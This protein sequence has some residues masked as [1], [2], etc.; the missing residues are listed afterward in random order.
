MKSEIPFSVILD[1]A[2][3]LFSVQLL[4]DNNRVRADISYENA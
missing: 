2:D 3:V 1:V 4:T